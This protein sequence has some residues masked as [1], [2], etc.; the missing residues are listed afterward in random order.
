MAAMVFLYMYSRGPLTAKINAARDAELAGDDGAKAK[1][2][3][4]HKL[5]VRIFSMQLL[6]LVASALYWA[7]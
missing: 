4:L 7:P 1:F 5:S 6:V 3:R 2:D